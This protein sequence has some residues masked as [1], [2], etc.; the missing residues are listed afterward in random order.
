M[1]NTTNVPT[2][3]LFMTTRVRYNLY[4]SKLLKSFSHD[5]SNFFYGPSMKFLA[6]LKK[7]R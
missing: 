5:P 4:L 7:L 1:S 3:P 2:N 6:F